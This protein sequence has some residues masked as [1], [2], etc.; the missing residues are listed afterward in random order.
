MRDIKDRSRGT[1]KPMSTSP[2]MS[3]TSP[4]IGHDR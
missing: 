3:F 2:A 4:H 1:M